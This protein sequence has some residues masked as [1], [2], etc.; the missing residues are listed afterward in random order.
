[1][2]DFMFADNAEA[3]VR[4]AVESFKPE[5][6]GISIRNID[7]LI[8]KTEFSLPA[9]QQCVSWIRSESSAPIV[10]GGPGFSLF[11]EEILDILNLDYGVVGEGDVAFPQLVERLVKGGP[12]DDIGGL[13]Y[14]KD[15][16]LKTN[17]PCPVS[18]LDTIPFQAIDLI[19]AKRYD[20]ARGAMGVFTRK[21]CPLRCSYC[22]EAA[23]HG[24][25]V[26]L[27][28]PV[29]VV[30]EMQYIMEKAG[31]RYFDFA[32]TT[33][34]SPRSHAVAVCREIIGRK[35][36]L[37]FEVELSPIHQD[38]ES[39]RLLK[40]AGCQGVDLTVDSGS[41]K[42]LRSLHKGFK[43]EDALAAAHLYDKVG[44]P[45]T[46]GF[47]LGGPGE[48]RETVE[49]TVD[50]ARR[51]PRPSAVYFAVGIRVFRQTELY[52][53]LCQA[54]PVLAQ[55]SLLTPKF[56]VSEEFD[57]HCAELLLAACREVSSFYISDIFYKPV[58]KWVLKGSTWAN[59]RPAWKV[60]SV[61]KYIQK[62][63]QF[64]GDGLTWDSN[65]RAFV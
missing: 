11:A 14:R 43:A 60:G 31:V 12:V 19:D 13:C 26:R 35:L 62:V 49:A 28:S 32:D 1:M 27:R 10:L 45:Y 63:L 34:N 59:V 42:M 4:S 47:L 36:N 23:F 44:I 18:D 33:F 25:L 52:H 51:L 61:P 54:N 21:A 39:V 20:R 46:A 58:M 17:P 6:V 41:D 50:L 30:D 7:A 29:R 38:E 37:Q 5:L 48:N 2:A 64:G 53:Q 22:P 65:R 16:K 56:Y 57:K 3:M 24:N 8:S 15:G 55:E 40:A 9:L